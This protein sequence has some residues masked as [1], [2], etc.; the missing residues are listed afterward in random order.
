MLKASLYTMNWTSYEIFVPIIIGIHWCFT[1]QKATSAI[2]FCCEV[3]L[4]VNSHHKTSFQSIDSHWFFKEIFP[5][6]LSSLM[7]IMDFP[8]LCHLCSCSHVYHKV[9]VLSCTNSVY[10][11]W[12][13]FLIFQYCNINVHLKLSC[14]NFIPCVF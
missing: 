5:P 4:L 6:A 8:N 3:F 9:P 10:V 2:E 14:H 1:V 12:A 13:C 7:C 11:I